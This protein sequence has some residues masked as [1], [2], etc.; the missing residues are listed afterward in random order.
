MRMINYEVSDTRKR[1]ILNVYYANNYTSIS[2]I[3][4]HT[5]LLFVFGK[6]PD[7]LFINTMH[8]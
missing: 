6:M 5:Y 3:L 2:Y 8:S 7:A 4:I 1:P